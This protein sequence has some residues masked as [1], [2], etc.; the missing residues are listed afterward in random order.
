MDENML[1]ETAALAGKILLSS[2]AEVFRVE[3]TIRYILTRSSYQTKEAIVFA[4]GLFV[5]MDDPEKESISL[6][7]R[8]PGRSTNVNRVCLVNDVSR[9]FCEG[10]I[11]VEKAYEKLQKIETSL[12]SPDWMK[13]LGIIGVSASFTAIFGGGWYDVIPTAMVGAVLAVADWL[14]K[15]IHLND[16]FINAVGAFMVAFSALLIERFLI[17]GCNTDVMII[18]PIMT[19]VPGVC[20]TTACRDTLNGDYGAGSARMLEAIVVAL[21]VAAGVGAGIVSFDALFGGAV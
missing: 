5:A 12:Q 2:G 17:P 1:I 16:F 3:E 10:R 18:S 4:T 14:E 19:L 11:S 13:A 15:K 21:A 6:M 9:Q 8:I 20:F 7:R